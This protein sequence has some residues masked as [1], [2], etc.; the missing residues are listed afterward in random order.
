MIFAGH[1]H[2]FK[3]GKIGS[4]RYIVS[5][6]GGMLTHIPAYDGGF[7][8]YVVVRVHGDYIDYEVR[9][10]FPPLWEYLTYYMWKDLFYF[11]KDVVF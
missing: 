9:K 6:G 3:A 5:G 4:V 1:E 11:L 10:I 7:L 2:M 8:H